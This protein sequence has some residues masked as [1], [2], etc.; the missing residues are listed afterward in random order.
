MKK[1]ML[2]VPGPT[3]VPPEVLQAMGKQMINHRGAA[4]GEL[5]SEVNHLIKKV[6][7]TENHVLIFPGAGTGAMEAAVV[8]LT[9]PGERVLLATIGAFGDRFGDI[10]EGHGVIVE[11]VEAEWGMAID[12]QAVKEKLENNREIKKLFITHNETSTGVTN[13]LKAVKDAI[14]DDVLMIV[15][16]VSGLGGIDLRMDE[17]GIDVVVTGSQKALMIPPGLAFIALNDRAWKVVEENKAP[18]YYWDFKLAR[19]FLEKN[20]P[21]TPYTPAVSLLYALQASLRLII[22]EGLENVFARHELMAKAIRAGV[23]AL[24]LKMLAED[25]VASHTVTAVYSPEGIDVG[26][27]RKLMREKYGITLAGGQK[28]L[29]GK[30]FR[31]G[32]LG[33][34]DW[35]DVVTVLAGLELALKE[36]GYP[37]E[38]GTA[39]K[40]AQ[41]I[42]F[43]GR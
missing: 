9:E 14:P 12:P 15:D 26:K 43:A 22:E 38:F 42:L 28:K 8:N 1:Q 3:P 10:L 16:A 25:D 11:R 5:F 7:Q 18:K 23:K 39:I 35:P 40:A 4:F 21:E 20:P 17:W 24:G 41:E 36:L 31:I 33:Y 29:E 37:V 27:L 19:K 13:D 32:H 2:M 6:F 34:V 30:I